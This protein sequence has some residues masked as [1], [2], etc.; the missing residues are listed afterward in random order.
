[1]I[2][3][4]PA[5]PDDSDAI[6]RVLLA[7]FPTP[8]EAKLVARLCDHDHDELS[9][10]AEIDGNVVGHILFSPVTVEREGRVIAGGLGLAPIAVDPAHQRRGIG[11]EL[12][13]AGLSALQAFACPFV[14]VLGEPAY[15]QRFGFAAASRFGLNNEYNVD[16]PFMALE[17]TPG[18]LPAAG[19]VQYGP[20]FAELA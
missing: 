17:L 12:I 3:I 2:S 7:A 10:V 8:Q 5:A 16:D 19:L 4:R 11:S 1:V 6:Q 14:V 20:E 13:R 18:G 15:Y 9:L